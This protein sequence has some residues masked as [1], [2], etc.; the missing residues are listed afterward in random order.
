VEQKQKMAEEVKEAQ[1]TIGKTLNE[2]KTD[3][4]KA[5]SKSLNPLFNWEIKQDSPVV[6]VFKSARMRNTILDLVLLSPERELTFLVKGGEKVKINTEGFEG[7]YFA[8]Y[9]AV[10]LASQ[11]L[12]LVVAD[13][14][15]KKIQLSADA[16]RVL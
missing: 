13:H 4:R 11:K 8:L 7:S 3:M 15:K 5:L 14:V 1:A 12:P 16:V 10:K 9:K 6:S 2:A